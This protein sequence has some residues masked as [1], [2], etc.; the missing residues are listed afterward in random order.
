M[1]LERAKALIDELKR[2]LAFVEDVDNTLFHHNH[3][4]VGYHLNGD[5]EPI[6]DFVTDMDYE[7]INAARETIK[8]LEA[9]TKGEEN[10]PLNKTVY[11]NARK[12]DYIMF[13]E[14]F[15]LKFRK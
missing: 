13:C 8:R 1:N 2:L 3:A 6:M 11:N 9:S 12:L 10:L 4:V 5:H 15:N 7:A 14:W